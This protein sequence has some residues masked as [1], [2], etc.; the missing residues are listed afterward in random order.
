M[1]CVK[2]FNGRFKS[3]FGTMTKYK[4]A[5]NDNKEE[6]DMWR[7]VCVNQVKKT[8]KTNVRL[9]S[10]AA[11][12]EYAEAKQVVT[13]KK[14]AYTGIEEPD[15]EVWQ[16]ALYTKEFGDHRTNGKGHVKGHPIPQ[17]L[18]IAASWDVGTSAGGSF[19][20]FKL[21]IYIN[22]I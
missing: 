17:N 14:K 19:N 20:H 1:Y 8:G 12:A 16:E 4:I 5:H 7:L 22:S 15:D 9:T 21:P 6:F 2:T 11:E 10:G 13:H 18:Y 3:R